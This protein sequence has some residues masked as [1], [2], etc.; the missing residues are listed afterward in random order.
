MDPVKEIPHKWKLHCEV[1]TNINTVK[2]LK[3][4]LIDD[5]VNKVFYYNNKIKIIYRCLSKDW[6]VIS[7]NNEKE[8]ENF[9]NITNALNHARKRM[10]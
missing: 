8:N 1:N 9:D 3:N 5:V 6:M 4:I 7:M 2:D 10:E